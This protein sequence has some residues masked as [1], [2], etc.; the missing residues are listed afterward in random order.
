MYPGIVHVLAVCDFHRVQVFDCRM[1]CLHKLLFERIFR[2]L[3][4]VSDCY[5]NFCSGLRE[6]GQF[7]HARLN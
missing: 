1:E 2:Y 5:E 6:I 3:N 4:E 7:A